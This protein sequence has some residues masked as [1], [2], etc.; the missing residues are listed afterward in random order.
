MDTAAEI[1]L[2]DSQPTAL[3]VDITQV[4]NRQI[5]AWLKTTG[6]HLYVGNHPAQPLLQ[7]TDSPKPEDFNSL[8]CAVRT[9]F[10][11]AYHL[12]DETELVTK[13]I[14]LSPDPQADGINNTPFTKHEQATTLPSSYI[15]YGIRLLT[16]LLR[17]SVEGFEMNLPQNVEDA[18]SQLRDPSAELTSD[19]IHKLF[20]ALWTTN[21]TTVRVDKITD[22]TVRFLALATLLPNGGW[23]EPKDVTYILARF[24]Y[25]MRLTFL[26]EMH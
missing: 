6:W 18:L 10:I 15:P 19:S 5:S 1:A 3:N 7:W 16:M 14:L 9:Y 4:N 11:E 24:F 12:I 21:W 22:P 13:Q 20:F 2:L 8:A 23:K 17:P 25:L 26:Y